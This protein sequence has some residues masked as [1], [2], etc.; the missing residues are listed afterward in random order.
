MTKQKCILSLAILLIYGC[1]QT[2]QGLQEWK[3][4]HIHNP[5]F[6]P[7]QTYLD[8]TVIKIPFKIPDRH[9]LLQATINREKTVWFMLDTG[10]SGVV[11]SKRIARKMNLPFS[12]NTT[13]VST[14]SGRAFFSPLLRVNSLRVGGAEFKTFDAV[15]LDLRDLRRKLKHEVD[16][17]LGFPLFANI[18]LTIDY[19]QQTIFLEKGRLPEKGKEIFDYDLINH[20]P[21]LPIPWKGTTVPALIDTGS[22]HFLTLPKALAD[23]LILSYTMRERVW[24][25]EGTRYDLTGDLEEVQIGQYLISYPRIN[26]SEVSKGI[27]GFVFLH[28]FVI[29]FDH[30]QKKVRI[31]KPSATQEKIEIYKDALSLYQ[32]REA[33]TGHASFQYHLGW[34]Y[35]KGYGV[36]KNISMAIRWYQEAA[37][38][39]NLKAQQALESLEGTGTTIKM[40]WG[41]KPFK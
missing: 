9:I 37:E 21:Y 25:I 8:E 38:Q 19:P 4:H 11:V 10:T 35:H 5:Q 20:K 32:K 18:L 33:E 41:I 39:G 27:L 28:H 14:P 24:N 29:T 23:D 3:P 16:G 6:I 17:I 31:T 15:Q 36:G 13:K 30:L 34:I 1:S 7:Q 26:F 22:S 2:F 40:D 12:E